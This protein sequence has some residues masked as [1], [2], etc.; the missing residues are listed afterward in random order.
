MG[1]LG[2]DTVKGGGCKDRFNGGDGYDVIRGGNGNDHLTS[3]FATDTFVFER[4]SFDDD[5]ITD[6]PPG[7]DMLELDDALW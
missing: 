5:V 6:C 2:R 1:V 4:T 3:G 7:T